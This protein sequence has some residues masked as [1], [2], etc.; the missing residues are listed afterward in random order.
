MS[1]LPASPNWFERHRRLLLLG[2]P[3]LVLLVTGALYVNSLRHV[4]TDD[5]YVAAPRTQIS[6]NV[7]GRVVDIRVKDNQVVH[8]GEVLFKLDDREFVIAVA[9]ARARLAQARLDIAALKASYRQHQAEVVSA[10]ETLDYQ[11]HELNRTQRLAS[12]GIASQAQLDQIRHAWIQA[13][14]KVKASEQEKENVLA[15]LNHQPDQDIAAHPM[16]QQ[17][18]ATL[19]KALLNL[20]YTTITAPQEG[21]VSKV[22]QL[23]VGN[24]VAASAPV[25]A[26]VSS[27]RIWVE[28]N[29]RETDLAQILPGQSATVEI[30]AYPDHRF[31][32]HV[33]SLSPGTGSSFALLP[34]EN[35]TGNWVKVVQRLPVRISIEDV[36]AH[37]PLQSGLSAFVEVDIRHDPH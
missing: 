10:R 31:H 32:G 27:G 34:P 30:D 6:S 20:S 18:Q 19:D 37:H 36:D 29:F 33:Q 26:L 28:A 35:A 23:Q 12:Q 17:A 7:A 21:I 22:E 24:Y 16:V 14:Q 9:E 2:G 15:A 8:P 11:H 4:S 1:N 5:A 13:E 25:F 3:V